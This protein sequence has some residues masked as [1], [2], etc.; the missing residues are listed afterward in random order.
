MTRRGERRSLVAFLGGEEAL[1]VEGC[2]AAGAGRG[3][4]LPVG[5]VGDVAGDED[6]GDVRR[7]RAGVREQ[8]AG[9]VV[10]EL[11]D[12]ER[13]V[14]IVADRHEDAVGRQVP[15]LIGACVA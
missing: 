8:V 7:G 4:R 11:V 1:R 3:D 15:D 9:L 14:R 12:E 13:R 6:A 5:V 10:V 2:H